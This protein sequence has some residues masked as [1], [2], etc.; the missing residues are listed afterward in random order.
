M[1]SELEETLAWLADNTAMT[2]AALSSTSLLDRANEDAPVSKTELDKMIARTGFIEAV[3]LEF[4][5][6][7]SQHIA[8]ATSP[9]SLNQSSF[10]QGKYF[11]GYEYE[12]HAIQVT[13]SPGSSSTV[14]GTRPSAWVYKYTKDVDYNLLAWIVMNHLRTVDT[15]RLKCV[16]LTGWGI[17]ARMLYSEI[18][19]PVRFYDGGVEMFE[20]YDDDTPNYRQDRASD[21]GEEELT[22]WLGDKA[23]VL[24]TSEVQ[25]RGAECDSVIFVTR[26]WA[27]YI[28]SSRRSPL[29]RAVAGL[30]VITSDYKLRVQEMGRNWDVEMILEK[31]TGES[32]SET[33]YEL[34]T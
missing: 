20:N 18:N 7:S 24:I 31:G 26:E 10:K 11:P 19:T 15:K 4:I 8:A 6:R 3:H 12:S 2:L 34:I 17:S 23:G 33:E 32:D 1:T 25:F 5:M 29:T 13:I 9:D 30:L 27:S 16:V 14:P 21:G 28:G 22:A